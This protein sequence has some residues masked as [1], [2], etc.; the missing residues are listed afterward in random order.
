MLEGEAL[1]KVLEKHTPKHIPKRK[2]SG[3]EA[4]LQIGAS[5]YSPEYM[6]ILKGSTGSEKAKDKKGNNV[7]KQKV[8]IFS[9]MKKACQ[10]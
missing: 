3:R 7:K 6:E 2:G 8:M 5:R 10:I 9:L 4:K 1:E